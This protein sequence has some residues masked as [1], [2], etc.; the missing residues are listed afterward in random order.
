MGK[1]YLE[2]PSVSMAS[3]YADSDVITPIIFVLS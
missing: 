2:T 1:F 3:I